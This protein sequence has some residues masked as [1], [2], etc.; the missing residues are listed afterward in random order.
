[1]A[2][3][4]FRLAPSWVGGCV[5]CGFTKKAPKRRKDGSFS[6]W[7][8]VG[9][10]GGPS[11]SVLLFFFREAVVQHLCFKQLSWSRFFIHHT[12]SSMFP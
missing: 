3:E 5:S 8:C 7:G 4:S 6:R 9:D 10:L 12:R 1:M 2:G 11:L